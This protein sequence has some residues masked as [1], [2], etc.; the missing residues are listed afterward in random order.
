VSA[1]DEDIE[2]VL[3]GTPKKP[4]P[5]GGLK[6]QKPLRQTRREREA[7][8]KL[9]QHASLRATATTSSGQIEAVKVKE[10]VTV[11]WL[12]AVFGKSGE[13]VRLRL[14]D[15]PPVSQ[16]GRAFRYNIA[17]AAAYLVDPK[18][19]ITKYLR[20]LKSSDLPAHLQKEIWDARLK[21]QK[22]E[23]L[24]GDLWHTQDVMAVLSGTF[25]IIKSSIQLWPDTVERQVG[26][27]NEQRALLIDLGDTLQNEIHQGLVDSAKERS[28]KAA[29]ADV[30]PT[31]TVS[32]D[33]DDLEDVL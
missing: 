3:G 23:A 8:D 26:L 22:W 11:A 9:A 21:R 25:A 12:A 19:D 14:A 7:A 2:S 20:D 28:T 32:D 30:E 1:Y 10:G 29:I 31:E 5:H 17:E 18:I 24:A 4:L 15:C 13:W 33:D 16:H 6:P 27:S